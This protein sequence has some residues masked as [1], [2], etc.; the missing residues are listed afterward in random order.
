MFWAN[1]RASP[2]KLSIFSCLSWACAAFG[3]IFGDTRAEMDMRA[4]HYAPKGHGRLGDMGFGE[5]LGYSFGRT[6][7][8]DATAFEVPCGHDGFLCV[9][10]AA[11]HGSRMFDAA[12]LC[13]DRGSRRLFRVV[14]LR[15]LPRSMDDIGVEKLL[16][17]VS[18]ACDHLYGIPLQIPPR[19]A[20]RGL[21]RSRVG[22]WTAKGG[23][24]TFSIALSLSP[25]ADGLMLIEVTV[26]NA[27]ARR[28]P[29]GHAD[30][31][32]EI[33]VEVDGL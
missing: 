15:A 24:S 2:L 6:N 4:A 12:V 18:R 21:L 26:E 7:S 22:E 16:K 8:C 17:S 20:I 13:H 27:R 32:G 9:T 31:M 19:R 14:G 1:R 3:V 28:C 33:E 23:D 29:A 11:V 25:R 5:F 30:T 10:N